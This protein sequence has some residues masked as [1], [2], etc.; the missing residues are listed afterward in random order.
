MAI[1]DKSRKLLWGRSGNR[2]ASCKVELTQASTAR[3]PDSIIGDECHIVSSKSRGPRYDGSLAAD[4]D[5]DSYDNLILLCKVHHKL[6]DD[7]PDTFDAEVLRELKTKHEQWVKARLSSV[8]AGTPEES[9]SRPQ[10]Q[11]ERF[12]NRLNSGQEILDVVGGAYQ[13]GLTYDDPETQGEMELISTFLQE[14]QDWGELY[15]ELESGRRVEAA[16][17][18]SQMLK[19]VEAAGFWVFG[20]RD[21]EPLSIGSQD[22]PPVPTAF[23]RIVRDTNESIIRFESP[24]ADD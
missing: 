1:T 8:R 14:V 13:F 20:L 6:V 12:L 3:D 7:Q 2:C 16:F 17:Q 21:K 23:M 10:S 18:L 19:D 9:G 15:A 22:L 4:F 5:H 24:S 11:S